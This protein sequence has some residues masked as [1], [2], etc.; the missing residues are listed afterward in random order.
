[1]PEELHSD[2]LRKLAAAA[3]LAF[4]G[5]CSTYLKS[6]AARQ[7]TFSSRHPLP[8]RQWRIVRGA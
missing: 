5:T 8:G 2:E 1:M 4:A 7:G 6:V 3:A